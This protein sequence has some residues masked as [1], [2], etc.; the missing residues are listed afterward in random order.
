MLPFH[1]YNTGVVNFEAEDYDLFDSCKFIFTSTVLVYSVPFNLLLL[2][3]KH[4]R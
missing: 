2:I 1:V 4:E 3:P